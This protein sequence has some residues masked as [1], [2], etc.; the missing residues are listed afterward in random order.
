MTRLVVTADDLGYSEIRDG[1]ILDAFA[2]G[3]VTR[4]T[5]MTNGKSAVR[6]AQ[7]AR[8][9]GL[10]VGLHL[11][12][13]EG[14]AVGKPPPRSLVGED[15]CFL[16]PPTLAERARKGLLEPAD[17][18]REIVAQITR[19]QE[20]VGHLPRH[21]DGHNHA[22]VLEPVAA[23]LATVMRDAGIPEVRVPEETW[24][25]ATFLDALPPGKEA[26]YRGVSQD[27]ERAF[28]EHFAKCG[29]ARSSEA[30][31][32]MG[33]MG[34]FLTPQ[35]VADALLALPSSVQSIELMVHP[36]RCCVGGE[37]TEGCW[38]RAPDAFSQSPER[39]M[40]LAVL[41]DPNLCTFL[42][43]D[44]GL[45]L[46]AYA[47]G[48]QRDEESKEDPRRLEVKAELSLCTNETPAT[49]RILDKH[50]VSIVMGINAKRVGH[51]SIPLYKESKRRI[52]IVT[53]GTDVNCSLQDECVLEVFR[54][55]NGIVSFNAA[56]RDV[57]ASLTSSPV[58]VIPQAVDTSF[59]HNSSFSI[60]ES[61]GLDASAR[62]LLLVC[63]LRKVKAP[64]YLRPVWPQVRERLAGVTM[65]IVGPVLDEKVAA[66]V[67]E[68]VRDT[69]DEV[70]AS[71]LR[72]PMLPHACLLRAIADADALVNTSESEGM[73]GAILEAM[74]LGTPV[75]ARVNAG[76]CELVTEGRT[77]LLFD[78]PE[79]FLDQAARLWEDA[80]LRASIVHGAKAVIESQHS[81]AAEQRAYTELL[82]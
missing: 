66:D 82:A 37:T 7:Q 62:I 60:R 54:A 19:F 77:G 38:Q 76:N 81:T 9:A 53:G 52:Y 42:E 39:E 44:L 57:L 79:A 40:E 29:I 24:L 22:H 80:S 41:K 25:S 51:L 4:A 33:L 17:L 2:A 8:D 28:R 34:R 47:N 73:S 23:V 36:G 11:N 45:S 78:S 58:T 10:P 74:A 75:L 35:T 43:K 65:V 59:V 56:M 16:G 70:A 48:L 13:T 14:A 21:V 67:D 50:K 15:G 20:L 63:G 32:G 64:S 27:A 61:C 3:L 26:F 12:V 30:F 5:L 71:V 68:W 1:G 18:E 49:R 72:H 55:C 31:I 46:C 69:N 6:A